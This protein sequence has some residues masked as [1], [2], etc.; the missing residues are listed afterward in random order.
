L[1]FLFL[2]TVVTLA[3]LT[4]CTSRSAAGRTELVVY[5]A[6]S[7]TD[8]FPAIAD[9]FEDEHPEVRIIFNF[10]GSATLR[11]QLEFGAPADVYAAA[12]SI[13]MRLAVDAGVVDSTVKVFASN[14]MAIVVPAN[15]AVVKSLVDIGNP[16]VKVV[17][18]SDQVPA[19]AYTLE[20]LAKMGTARAVGGEPGFQSSV[21]SNVVSREMNVREV[22][23]KV[24]LGEADVGFVYAT[25]AT[26]LA[27]G[28]RVGVLA[29][30]VAQNVTTHLLVGMV[31]DSDQR[32]L[33][34]MFIEFATSAEGTT[35]LTQAG[36]GP[37]VPMGGPSR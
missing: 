23:A 35:I 19:G 3:A 24:V 17:L 18:A 12:D 13:Q 34:A 6:S 14:S 5:A 8:A 28:N 27:N 33:A 9:A 20:L 1:L 16:G 37:A 4:G 21:L 22:L 31:N 11:S 32:D 2:A 15:G 30:P 25:D 26:R 7:L 29:V 36:F 10:S